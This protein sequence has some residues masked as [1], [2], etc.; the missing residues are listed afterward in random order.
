MNYLVFIGFPYLF[1]ICKNNLHMLQQNFYNENN[2]YLK[3]GKNNIS[4]ILNKI[5]IILLIINLLS[6][7]FDNH[8]LLLI[9]LGYI[10]LYVIKNDENKKEQVKIPLKVT[11][12]LKR[13]VF[14]I[15]F[16]YLIP[17]ILF[18]VFNKNIYLNIFVL[19]VFMNFF[20]VYIANVINIPIERIVFNTYK[21]KA[22]KKLKSMNFLEVIGITGSYGKT[23]S[24]NIL[25]DILSVKLNVFAT[26]KNYNTQYGL[27]LSINN[28]LDKFNDIFIAEMGAFKKGRIK[29]LCNLVKPKYGI[30]TS[31]GTAH[32]ETFG[33]RENIQE[34]KFE[35]IESLPS[36][37]LGI[38]NRDDPYQVSYKLKNNCNIIWIGIDN[39]QA[40]IYATNIKMDSKGMNF[41]VIFKNKNVKEKFHTKLLGIPNIYN[42]LAG[43]A[44]GDYKNMSI[45]E[46]QLGVEKILPVEHRLELKKV[47]NK[48]IIDDAY[49]SNPVGASMALDVL[50]LMK[51]FKVV[52]TPGMIELGEEQYRHNKEFGSKISRVA[53]LVIL[54]GKKQTKPIYDGLIE[55]KY[56]DS[57][58]K[59]IND[60]KE[61]FTIVDNLKIKEETYILLENDLPDIFNEK[62]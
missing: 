34:G 25:N 6:L 10:F 12:R 39:K 21:I 13:L 29:L 42:I 57:K 41:D 38:L 24:K 35:L 4:K 52:V 2:R 11:S 62:E 51:G 40:D 16:I 19:L 18:I 14:T 58:I 53:D 54:V 26:P 43:I 30:I 1:L 46:L 28:Y 47:N 9:N 48:Y 8:Y 5:E 44:F 45:K 23:S 3:W 59:I 60:V 50:N 15:I 22:Q 7:V 32:L 20:V 37:G 31:I 61:A 36:D 55:S 33:S 49:N 56:D 17:I 27:I